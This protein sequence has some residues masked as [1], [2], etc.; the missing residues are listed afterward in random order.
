MAR[1]HLN[2]ALRLLPTDPDPQLDRATRERIQTQA[3]ALLARL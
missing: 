2:E 1:T 3:T